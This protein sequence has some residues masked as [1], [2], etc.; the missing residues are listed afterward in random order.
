[1]FKSISRF[2]VT[3]TTKNPSI[4]NSLPEKFDPRKSKYS[5]LI[6]TKNIKTKLERKDAPSYLQDE[7]K[8]QDELKKNFEI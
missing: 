5:G 6:E 1:M 4:K 3:T 8:V 7:I 2:F